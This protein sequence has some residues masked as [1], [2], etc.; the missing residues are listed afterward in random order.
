MSTVPAPTPVPLPSRIPSTV[1][2]PL[3]RGTHEFTYYPVLHRK[4][5]GNAACS[6]GASCFVGSGYRRTTAAGDLEILVTWSWCLERLLVQRAATRGFFR[7]SRSPRP[8][9]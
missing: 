2:W 3:S 1:C 5:I 4:P 9:L 6:V 7:E 8:A